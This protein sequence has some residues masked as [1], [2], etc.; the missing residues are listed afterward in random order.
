MSKKKKKKSK[1][2]GYYTFMVL[3]GFDQPYFQY[4]RR[5]DDLNKAEKYSL[6]V[7]TNS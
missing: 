5:E 2:K 3:A 1:E 7:L 4:S 6:K